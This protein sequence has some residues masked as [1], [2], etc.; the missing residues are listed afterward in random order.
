MH[1]ESCIESKRASPN[2]IK[3]P[4]RDFAKIHCEINRLER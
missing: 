2:V 3:Y 1:N 4:P